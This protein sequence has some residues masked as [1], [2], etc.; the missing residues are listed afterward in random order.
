MTT[1]E[2]ALVALTAIVVIAMIALATVE[3]FSHWRKK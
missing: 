2:V 3:L 1:T